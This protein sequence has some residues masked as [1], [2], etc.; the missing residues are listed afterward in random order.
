MNDRRCFRYWSDPS[1]NIRRMDTVDQ[2]VIATVTDACTDQELGALADIVTF[3]DFHPFVQ[4][5]FRNPTKPQ[6]PCQLRG[7]HEGENHIDYQGD[8]WNEAQVGVNGDL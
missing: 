2:E 8:V 1:G 4:C 3:S 7:G 6:C 5:K